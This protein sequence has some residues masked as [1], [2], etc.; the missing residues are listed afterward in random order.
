MPTKV[1][2][3]AGF[4]RSHAGREPCRCRRSRGTPRSG[5]AVDEG[6]EAL[7]SNQLNASADFLLTQED[8]HR[9]LVVSSAA[10][11]RHGV[12]ELLLVE[13]GFHQASRSPAH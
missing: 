1:E 12:E 11:G 13:V 5:E 10:H 4:R 3:A 9:C 6:V 7:V 2:Q 8:D